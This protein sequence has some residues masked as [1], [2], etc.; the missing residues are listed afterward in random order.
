MSACPAEA[1]VQVQANASAQRHEWRH[2]SDGC[3]E[4]RTATTSMAPS[5]RMQTPDPSSSVPA[6]RIV[7]GRP[8]ARV[9]TA[10]HIPG[11]PA[12][13]S[14][15]FPPKR[16][17]SNSSYDEL[18]TTLR[19]MSS[20]GQGSMSVCTAIRLPSVGQ[21]FGSHPRAVHVSRSSRV[22]WRQRAWL[23]HWRAG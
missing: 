1:E 20:S 8:V 15:S 10:H 18:S 7:G 3:L 19:L 17:S 12:C 13:V 23:S 21:L 5:T 16:S 2:P 4:C 6:S 9:T 22:S 14:P 11:I